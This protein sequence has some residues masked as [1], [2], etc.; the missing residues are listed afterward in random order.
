M[1]AK[2][3]V[4]IELPYVSRLK[5]REMVSLIPKEKKQELAFALCLS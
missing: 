5:V 1:M 2:I 3:P 4:L